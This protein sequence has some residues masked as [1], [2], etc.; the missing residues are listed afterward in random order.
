MPTLSYSS[1]GGDVDTGGLSTSNLT[2]TYEASLF[3]PP[4][5]Y[6]SNDGSFDQ[7]KRPS[8]WTIFAEGDLHSG[9]KVHLAAADGRFLRSDGREGTPPA[10][11]KDHNETTMW[12]LLY[13]VGG[14]PTAETPV[15]FKSP[16]SGGG[17][18]EPCL[19]NDT[20]TGGWGG[21]V[22]GMYSWCPEGRGD[23]FWT[24]HGLRSAGSSNGPL[25]IHE[26]RYGWAGDLWSAAL[27]SGAHHGGGAKDVTDLVRSMVINDELHINP[28]SAPMYMN[29]T[30]WAETAHD[31]P[32]PRKL[33][34]RYSYGDGDAVTVE[35]LAVPW[36]TVA[37]HVN[38]HM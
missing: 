14:R 34:V 32:I 3:S 6:L 18:G 16:T 36:E 20:P 26:A 31:P 29:L 11:A 15:Q 37:L 28:S 12:L 8:P 33:A 7:S 38:R 27:G 24:L 21:T 23:A 35:T 17:G 25:R 2:G 1:G 10:W 4:S 22:R 9:C 19:C 5:K 30:F 13:S